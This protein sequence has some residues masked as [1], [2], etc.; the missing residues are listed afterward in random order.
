MPTSTSERYRGHCLYHCGVP[1]KYWL[2]AALW[3]AVIMGL[4]SDVGSAEHTEHWLVP[5]LRLM[6]PWATPTQI[7]ALH[8]LVRKA[9]HLTEYAILATLWYRA[10]T[11]SRH[12]SAR[13]AAALAF[14]ISLIWAVLDEARQS[15]VPTR[16]ASAMDVALDAT[17]ALIAMLIATIGWRTI[18]ERTTTLLL[19][20]GFIG[21]AA[22]LILNAITGVPSGLLWL[23]AP[24]AALL[25]I[26]RSMYTRHARHH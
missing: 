22:V 7:D 4:S 18:L 23:T 1:V 17:G 8:G 15:L 21:G 3:M 14:A 12:L 26:A 19:W 25:L 2:P 6:A 16:T 9:G 20:T 24:L 11:R 5:L 10:L 13:P